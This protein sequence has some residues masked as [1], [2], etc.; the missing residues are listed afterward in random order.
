MDKPYGTSLKHLITIKSCSH[1]DYDYKVLPINLDI[2][3]KTSK[4]LIFLLHALFCLPAPI[5]V[6]A[7]GTGLREHVA[8][9]L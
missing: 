9:S 1:I 8:K 7:R 4:H 3:L 6:I 5:F 2:S